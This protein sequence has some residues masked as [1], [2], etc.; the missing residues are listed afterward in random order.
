MESTAR[1]ERFDQQ[2]SATPSYLWE[3][4][5]KPIQVRLPYALIDRLE[6]QVVETF[7][8]L[9]APGSEIGGV[10]V[11]KTAGGEPA[12]VSV[13]DCHLIEC[14]YSRGPLYRLSDADLSRFDRA[15]AQRSGT[16]STVIGFFRSHTRKGLMLDDE[17]MV[18]FESRFK[19]PRKIALLIR[20]L[21]TKASSAG[22]FIWENGKVQT[23]ASYLEFPFRSSQ[24]ARP[25]DDGGMAA[26]G[27]GGALPAPTVPKTGARAQIV[28]IASRRDVSP[29]VPNLAVETSAPSSVAGPPPVEAAPVVTSP[30]LPKPT[31]AAK[32]V[33]PAKENKVAPAPPAARE[34][35]AL[36]VKPTVEVKAAEVKP[37]EAKKVTP[38]PEVKPAAKSTPAL[39]AKTVKPVENPAA[40][41]EP[42]NLK[43]K[44]KEKEKEKPAASAATAPAP[45]SQALPAPSKASSTKVEV[46]EEEAPAGRSGKLTWIAISAVAAMIVIVG[47]FVYPGL[48]KTRAPKTGN[49]DN[50]TLSLRVERTGGELQLSWNREA[51]AIRGASKAVLSISDGPQ[52]QDVELDL[53]QLQKGSIAYTPASTDVI[54]QL[55]VTGKSQAKTASEMVRALSTR[56]SPMSPV[57]QAGATKQQA[58]TPNTPTPATP[59]PNNNNNSANNSQPNKPADKP[60]EPAADTNEDAPSKLARPTRQ[61]QAE[62]LSQR[63]HPVQTASSDIPDAPSLGRVDNSAVSSPLN[64]GNVAPPPPAP[65]P[66]APAPAAARPADSKAAPQ[67]GQIQQAQLLRRKEPEYPRMARETG[68]KGIVELTA[69]IGPDGKVKKVTVVK[70]H[71]MLV[72]AATD[73]VMQWV[74][75]PTILNGTPV[76]SQTQVLINFTGDR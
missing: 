62:S 61:F 52:H 30:A 70:G 72:K 15:I 16:D 43:G 26:A 19:D 56:P 36:E 64:M 76:E 24:L 51:D 48:L 37:V 41:P 71:P 32:E 65:A 18:I 40:P 2:S 46:D 27:L 39:P 44:E 17:D 4:S 34:V 75:K 12:I 23:D 55:E 6:G 53:A 57:D 14:D 59:T 7:R 21:A 11:G 69:T 54:F 66:A 49:T 42:K 74:Y 47:L 3:V 45:P 28:P 33:A 73:A 38:A 67:G 1:A 35:Q 22:I 20:P 29:T 60:A 13:E 10:L 9:N 31:P 58:S 63:L 68:A 8:S 25:G 5:K 50:S